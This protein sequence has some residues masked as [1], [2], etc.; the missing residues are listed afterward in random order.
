MRNL[1]REKKQGLIDLMPN[2][3]VCDCLSGGHLAMFLKTDSYITLV[4]DFLKSE[5]TSITVTSDRLDNKDV[6]AI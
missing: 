6:F 2:P 3:I 5:K 1:V 4:K